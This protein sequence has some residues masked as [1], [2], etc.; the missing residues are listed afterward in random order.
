M[1][2]RLENQ[3]IAGVCPRWISIKISVSNRYISTFIAAIVFQLRGAD[4]EHGL[5]YQQYQV[6]NE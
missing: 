3:S 4:A 6:V 1:S 5:D 2:K